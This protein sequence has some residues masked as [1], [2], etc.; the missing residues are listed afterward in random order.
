MNTT[1]LSI[2]A[3]VATLGFGVGLSSS[4]T[5]QTPPDCATVPPEGQCTANVLVYC[6]EMNQAEMI[7]CS[8]VPGATCT[9]VS[10][11]W[12]FDCATNA[13]AICADDDGGP[14][15]CLGTG[16]GCVLGA[17]QGTCE[18]NIPACNDLT[19]IGTCRGQRLMVDCYADQP[20]LLDCPA[21]GGTCGTGACVDIPEDGDCDDMELKC[22]TGLT[23]STDGVCVGATTPTDP[24]DAGMTGGDPYDAGTPP[25]SHKDAGVSN[26]GHPDASSAGIPNNGGGGEEILQD[27]SKTP[28]SSGGC[29]DVTPTGDRAL[30]FL[31]AIGVLMLRRR[32]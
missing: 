25:A 26:T 14:V 30:L 19:D 16:T 8:L 3:A 7:D 32:I 11:D 31:L 17:D 27:K 18:Q 20:L 1:Y 13:G 9:E 29:S 4:A 2:I 22:A 6:N 10:A 23:C 5:A 21:F 15:L 28:S 24:P 12:G